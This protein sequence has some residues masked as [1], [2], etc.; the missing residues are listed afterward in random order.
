MKPDGREGIIVLHELVASVEHARD[1]VIDAVRNLRPDQATFKPWP[2]E[3]WIIENI[4]HLYLAEISGLT[5]IWAA[6]RQVRE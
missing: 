1:A 3:W 5:K 2:D 6:A 4:E